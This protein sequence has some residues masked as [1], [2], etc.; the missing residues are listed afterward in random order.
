[1][2]HIQTAIQQGN[3]RAKLAFEMYIHHLRSAIGAMRMSLETLDALI[4]TAGV[5]E[6]SA[7]VRAATCQSLQFLGIELDPLK[8]LNA[9]S[10]CD[11]ATA[12]SPVRILVLRTQEDW[13]IAQTC[14]QHS[15]P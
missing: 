14:W 9:R 5:G 11:I 8:N 10:D 12:T 3:D 7:D 6:N 1:M 2:R 13:M 4:F 15:H